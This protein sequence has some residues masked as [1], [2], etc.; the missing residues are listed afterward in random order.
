[1]HQVLYFVHQKEFLTALLLFQRYEDWFIVSREVTIYTDNKT[2][3]KFEAKTLQQ[4]ERLGRGGE[5]FARFGK[6]VQFVWI[7]REENKLADSLA[8]INVLKSVPRPMGYGPPTA[9]L[10]RMTT[11]PRSSAVVDGIVSPSP[12]AGVQLMSPDFFRSINMTAYELD[13]VIAPLLPFVL[14]RHDGATPPELRGSHLKLATGLQLGRDGILYK[15]SSL[16]GN[17]RVVVPVS[18][19]NELLEAAHYYY[20]HM[21]ARQLHA[22]LVPHYWAPGFLLACKQLVRACLSCVGSRPVHRAHGFNANHD[23]PLYPF[24][25][26]YVDVVT[27]LVGSASGHNAV[28]LIMD[29]LTGFVRLGLYSTSS[30]ADDYIVALTSLVVRLFGAPAIINSDNGLVST[31]ACAWIA[32]LGG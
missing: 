14:A 16:Y 13:P 4:R 8:A 30:N 23:L 25:Q 7:P 17:L 22:L 21:S 28:L 3:S 12:G 20:D 19:L 6:A 32:A 24:Q 9:S 5:Y 2:C 29:A 18:V 15:E 26:I 11:L 10:A 1:M 27:G 31:K